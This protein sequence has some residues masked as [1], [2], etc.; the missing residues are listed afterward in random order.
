MFLCAGARR[1]YADW[2]QL[3][4]GT[5]AHLRAISAA[6]RNSLE[7]TELVDEL[8]VKSEDFARL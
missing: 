6:D 8:T 7:L 1:L 4:P 3:A 5:V 2:E